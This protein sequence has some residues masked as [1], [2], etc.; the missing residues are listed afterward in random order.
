MLDGSTPPHVFERSSLTGVRYWNEVL[1]HYVRLFRH[2]CDSKFI[3]MDDNARPHC[4]LLVDEFLEIED[5]RRMDWP[6][7]SPDLN[8]ME[9]V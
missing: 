3:V 8:L 1:E 4:P 9:N 7:R 6:D 2:A 5:I